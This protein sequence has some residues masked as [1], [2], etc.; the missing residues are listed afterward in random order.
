MESK[1]LNNGFFFA[2]YIIKYRMYLLK[3]D[4]G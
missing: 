3:L 2:Q 4:L 1:L